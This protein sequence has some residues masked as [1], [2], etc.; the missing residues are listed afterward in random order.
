[1]TELSSRGHFF[2]GHTWCIPDSPVDPQER[3]FLRQIFFFD[4]LPVE[5]LIKGHP[6]ARRMECSTVRKRIR[7]DVQKRIVGPSKTREVCRSHKVVV[8]AVHTLE[9]MATCHQ[10]RKTL[11]GEQKYELSPLYSALMRAIVAAIGII[12][13][14]FPEHPRRKSRGDRWCSNVAPGG[15]FYARTSMYVSQGESYAQAT[16]VACTTSRRY[17]ASAMCLY[18]YIC[19]SFGVHEG[20][21]QLKREAL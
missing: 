19:A 6:E 5:V 18:V 10:A 12:S 14:E 3:Y 20:R 1:M 7:R 8:G 13:A 16:G 4:G 2:L 15:C 17:S 9:G 11:V 21:C